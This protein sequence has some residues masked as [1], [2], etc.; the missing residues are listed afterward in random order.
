MDVC[1]YMYIYAHKNVFVHVNKLLK[2]KLHYYFALKST[3]IK[4]TKNMCR[5][6]RHKRCTFI[7]MLV[8]FLSLNVCRWIFVCVH[9]YTHTH[10]Y[11]HTFYEIFTLILYIPLYTQRHALVLFCLFVL[12]CFV[13]FLFIFPFL[14]DDKIFLQFDSIFF[15]FEKIPSTHPTAFT[16]LIHFWFFSLLPL[17]VNASLHINTNMHQQPSFLSLSFSV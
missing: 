1:L 12:F 11:R 2:K 9:T 8:F 4:R 16:F 14:S 7:R 5:I 17:K 6:C 3:H 15:F 10:T 13:L